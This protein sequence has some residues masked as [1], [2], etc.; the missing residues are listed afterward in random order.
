MAT[1]EAGHGVRRGGP[2]PVQL[3][4]PYP[5]FPRLVFGRTAVRSAAFPANDA[6]GGQSVLIGSAA[7]TC[8][9]D[10]AARARG[11]L[12]ERVHNVLAG[13]AAASDP[14]GV[15]ATHTALRR[16][17]VP[18]LDPLSWP[19]LADRAEPVRETE[20]LWVPGESLTDGGQVL[21]PACA[22]HLAHR[23]P[24]GCAAPLRPGSVG[25]AA[26]RTRDEATTHAALE[27][28]ERDL[29]WRA[30]YG[31]GRRAAAVASGGGHGVPLRDGLAALGLSAAPLLLPGPG[32]TVCAVVCLHGDEGAGQSFGARAAFVSDEGTAPPTAVRAA[33]LE[34]LMVRWSLDTPAARAARRRLERCGWQEVDGPLEH[35]LYAFDRQ[36]ALARL[37]SGDRG[38]ARGCSTGEP[39]VGRLLAEHTGEDVVL[40]D[41]GAPGVPGGDAAVVRVVAPGARRLPA[42]ERPRPP[43]PG[44]THGPPPHPLG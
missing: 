39:A 16:K 17:G 5:A 13:R 1:G 15:V 23:P 6:A 21:V 26:H 25:L 2:W 4:T 37:L 24:A 12:T 33:A 40:V 28:L 19:E 43:S 14:S 36:D 3:F 31:E 44:S 38:P 35:A 18:A 41:T 9:A 22:V 11:E 7:G 29:V 32:G 8:E 10:V 30:W 20:L 42:R 27:I 34:A